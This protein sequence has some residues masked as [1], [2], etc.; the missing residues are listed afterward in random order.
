M[1]YVS[2]TPPMIPAL[3]VHCINEIEKRGLHEVSVSLHSHTNTRFL[4]Q[5]LLVFKAL[6]CQ[7][8]PS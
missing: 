8:A 3:V 1:D 7:R 2:G 4:K 5:I 6:F